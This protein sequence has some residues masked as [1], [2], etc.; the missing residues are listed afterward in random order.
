MA[1]YTKKTNNKNDCS[2]KQPNNDLYKNINDLL[3]QNNSFEFYKKFQSIMLDY[4]KPAYK[5][6]DLIAQNMNFVGNNNDERIKRYKILN[7]VFNLLDCSRYIPDN[8][9]NTI[10]FTDDTPY[11]EELQTFWRLT[12]RK[13]ELKQ[14]LGFPLCVYSN[15]TYRSLLKNEKSYYMYFLKNPTKTTSS[16]FTEINKNE[17]FLS[18]I[19]QKI[20][21]FYHL[22]QNG[23][24]SQNFIFEEIENRSMF[25]T[26]F[27]VMDLLFT[28]PIRSIIIL[29]PK[30]H[31]FPSSVI[32]P[33]EY[34]NSLDPTTLR[35]LNK[36]DAES[37]PEFLISNFPQFFHKS[38]YNS[39]SLAVMADMLPT[40][41]Y[42]Q[43]G[44]LY[45]VKKTD[46]K[47]V[48]YCI[49]LNKNTTHATLLYLF[50]STIP[51]TL[52]LST[53][54]FSLTELANFIF[55]RPNFIFD[56]AITNYF[57]GSRD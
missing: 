28:V 30:T 13:T 20:L 4:F 37:F 16:F 21:I 27:K 44:R 5:D 55:Y 12:T 3:L 1:S 43:V 31:L 35:T 50:D 18:E 56:D 15:R 26:T 45:L 52:S 34:F 38:I 51:N 57:I 36:S 29:S 54:T 42:P 49:I 53:Q 46:N 33:K 47:N 8:F 39:R 25:K 24:T 32:Q 7:H 9:F 14:V 17:T 41:F 11:R 19:F 23:I 2:E 22:Y 6:L 48:V 40:T 10:E